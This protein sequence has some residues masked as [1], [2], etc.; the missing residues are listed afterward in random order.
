[1]KE[2]FTFMNK[3]FAPH[4]EI[5][6][7][8]VD[9]AFREN[10]SKPRKVHTFNVSNVMRYLHSLGSPDL[11]SYHQ[12]RDRALVLFVMDMICQ[13]QCVSNLFKEVVRFQFDDDS[14]EAADRLK[15]VSIRL[16]RGKNYRPGDS[17]WSATFTIV[18]AKFQDEFWCSTPHNMLALQ[19]REEAEKKFDFPGFFPPTTQK[20]TKHSTLL[21]VTVA[22]ILQTTLENS[23]VVGYTPGDFRAAVGSRC[24]TQGVLLRKILDRGGWA[25]ENTFFKWYRKISDTLPTKMSEDLCVESAIRMVGTSGM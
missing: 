6:S 16:F 10:P 14:D 8:I 24:Y 3:F 20:P 2:T 12:L 13:R 4:S 18:A 17:D 11:L 22:K 19:R 25:G 21:P 9:A 5:M 1:M 7:L 15:S 23:G